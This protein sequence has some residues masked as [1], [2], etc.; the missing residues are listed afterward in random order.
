MKLPIL[1]FGLLLA[2]LTARAQSTNT[3]L[4]LDA[5]GGGALSAN[6]LVNYTAG[7]P[8]VGGTNASAS[9][10]YR[11]TGGFWA[12]ESIGLYSPAPTLDIVQISPTQVRLFW[13]LAGSDGYVLQRT[14]NLNPPIVWGNF[15]GTLATNGQFR[16]V[17]ESNNLHARFYRLR[18]P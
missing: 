11:I 6:Y 16:S 5:A 18:R 13:P 10:N 12:N 15:L 9:A 17:V 8:D 3:W 7:Q 14:A 4:T 2:G 1:G